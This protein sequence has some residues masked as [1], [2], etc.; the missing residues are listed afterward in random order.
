MS[1]RPQLFAA[2]VTP[3]TAL[4]ASA[5]PAMSDAVVSRM[6]SVLADSGP[7]M[8]D[9][10]RTQTVALLDPTQAGRPE[11]EEQVH[12]VRALAMVL[13]L[14]TQD[15][16]IADGDWVQ[17]AWED[18][19]KAAQGK[20]ADEAHGLLTALIRGRRCVFGQR[21]QTTWAYYGVLTKDEVV[22]IADALVAAGEAH[23]DLASSRVVDG[24]HDVLIGWF[25]AIATA[26]KDVFLWAD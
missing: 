8:L 17:D 13:G 12:C 15:A 22:R 3:L 26:D 19:L 18:Y 25:D 4:R 1:L 2:D 16:Q 20:L 14:M 23:P 11:N 10:A 5:D 24:F 9:L 21:I 6:A 7:A